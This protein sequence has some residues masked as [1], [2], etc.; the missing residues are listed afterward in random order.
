MH[1]RLPILGFRIDSRLAYVTDMLTMSDDSYH[2]LEG[3][4]IL[5]MNALRPTPHGS[6]QS[7]PE[8]LKAAR[9]LSTWGI[10]RDFML[11]SVANCLRTFILHTMGW[12]SIFDI[13]LSGIS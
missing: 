5:V 1:G 13:V 11:K 3:I 2:L 10:M 8:A 4:E 6:H 9:R 7:I 12:N